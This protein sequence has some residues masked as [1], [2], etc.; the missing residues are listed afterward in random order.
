MWCVP[1]RKPAV[2]SWLEAQLAEAAR[3]GKVSTTDLWLSLTRVASELDEALTDPPPWLR[4]WG[5]N[6]WRYAQERD[7]HESL[8][9]EH[10]GL[11]ALEE[12]WLQAANGGQIPQA[13]APPPLPKEPV[14]I[15]PGWERLQKLALGKPHYGQE[16]RIARLAAIVAALR[17]WTLGT[18]APTRRESYLRDAAT[19]GAMASSLHFK[20]FELTRDNQVLGW[21]IAAARSAALR[22]HT[23]DS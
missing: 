21:H 22:R 19:V 23:N 1:P 6:V 8:A 12:A 9:H 4:T 17:A 15:L 10:A 5:Q 2:P 11:E 3:Q 20:N 16:E 18:P 14:E 7:L 13:T